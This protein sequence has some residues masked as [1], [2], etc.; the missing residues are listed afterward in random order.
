M[1]FENAA[2]ASSSGVRRAWAA[3][4][5][6][7]SVAA[8][9]R[10]GEGDGARP[11]TPLGHR[12]GHNARTEA[13]L[14]TLLPTKVSRDQ[15]DKSKKKCRGGHAR[16]R[17]RPRRPAPPLAWNRSTECRPYDDTLIERDS[18]R[19]CNPR[20]RAPEPPRRLSSRPAAGRPRP[21]WQIVGGLSTYAC[22]C[23]RAG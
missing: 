17:P 23:H 12:S 22:T 8:T 5:S 16:E 3:G 4:G 21:K 15:R 9:G 1:A 6:P 18:A 14:P 11:R 10:G 19:W 13:G 7:R 20:F 2:A